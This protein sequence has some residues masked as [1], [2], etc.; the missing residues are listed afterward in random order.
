MF[1][2]VL[3]REALPKR[4]LGAGISVG[5]LVY[6]GVVALAFSASGRVEERERPDV[7]VTF[8]KPAPP[9]P[10]PP[11]PSAQRTQPRPRPREPARPRTLPSQAI[12]APTEVPDAEPPEQEPIESLASG[13]V[14]GGEAGGV[15]GGIPGGV[16]GGVV[17]GV[18]DGTGARMEFD[19][20]MTH[21][22]YLGGPSPQY[23]A[24]AL[25]REVQGTMIVKC[26][27]T[28]E[29]RVHGCRVLKSLPF[30][31]RAVVDALERRRYRPATLGGQ[32]VEVDYTFRITL[33]LPD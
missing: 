31:D 13:G 2:S 28:A 3:K 5:L 9:P 1:D 15:P 14:E 6:A 11:P 17:G 10:P 30:M 24:K 22:Q 19:E 25:E 4:R 33:R 7:E 32:P 20:R 18:V 12:V 23:T 8:V 29:G 21:P 27:V 16:T 26:V